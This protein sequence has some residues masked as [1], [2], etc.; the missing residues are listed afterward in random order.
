MILGIDLGTTNS[1][2]AIIKNGKPSFINFKNGI[3]MLASLVAFNDEGKIVVG[4]AAKIQ[5]LINPATCIKSVKSFMGTNKNI[6]LFNPKDEKSYTFTPI[7]LSSFILAEIKKEAELSLNT[8]IKNVVITVP[9]YFGEK[10]RQDTITAG[11]KA[12]LKVLRIINEPT[13]AAL[14]YAIYNKKLDNYKLM[15]YDIGGGTFDISMV[16]INR[17]I[18]EVIASDGDRRLGGDDIDKAIYDF[19]KNEL[20]KDEINELDENFYSTLFLEAEKAKISLSNGKEYTFNF[21]ELNFKKTLNSTDFNKI[22]EKILHKTLNHCFSV[23]EKSNIKNEEIEKILL[24]GGSSRIPLIKNMLEKNLG[25]IATHEVNPDL[26]VVSGA[27][28]QASIIEGSGLES[29][30]IDV[31]PHS[32]SVA[33]II[34]RN[35]KTIPNFCTKIIKKNTPLPYS[36]EEVFTP[37]DDEQQNVK[38]AIY[39]GE[40]DFEE[41][42]T[43][44]KEYNFSNIKNTKNAKILVNFSYDLDGTVGIDISEEGTQNKL[45]H[46]L[47]LGNKNSET[48]NPIFIN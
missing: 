9:A 26:A 31:A 15:I 29:I 32:L 38:I 35:G 18:V 36:V 27:A 34:E 28:I 43:L 45:Q 16:E 42:N 11:E 25:I 2:A 46:K 48:N 19:V 23:I 17:D 37:L 33:C 47:N 24:V 12:G 14:C 3:N 7:E 1:S 5:L 20:I 39:Q 40:S 44:I 8:E 4:E 21:K 13:A 41:N 6:T 30:L 10:A 22:S